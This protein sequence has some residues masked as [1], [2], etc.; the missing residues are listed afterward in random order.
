MAK[1]DNSIIHEYIVCRK[2]SKL[3]LELLIPN[4]KEECTCMYLVHNITSKIPNKFYVAD[5]ELKEWHMTPKIA[6]IEGFKIQIEKLKRHI[7]NDKSFLTDLESKL[8]Q[9]NLNN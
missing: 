6:E 2:S 8:L 4:K 7:K 9:L 1:P 3:G 5:F